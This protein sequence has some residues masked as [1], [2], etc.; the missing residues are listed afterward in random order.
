MTNPKL[1]VSEYAGGT[2]DPLKLTTMTAKAVEKI[3]DGAALEYEAV[4]D[5][6]EAD[7]KVIADKVREFAKGLREK[8]ITASQA[9]AVFT[10]KAADVLET[11][12]SLEAKY[13]TDFQAAQQQQIESDDGKPIPKFLGGGLAIAANGRLAD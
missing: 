1:P 8:A 5:K 13:T 9:V 4:A 12:R 6:L 7:A 10:D 11:V 2:G 3:G